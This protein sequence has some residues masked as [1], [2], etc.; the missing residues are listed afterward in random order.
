[1]DNFNFALIVP[2]IIL[3][4]ILVIVALVDLSKREKSKLQGESKLLWVL[5][6]LFIS[7]IGPILYLVIGRKKG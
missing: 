4:L 2:L 5:I 7:T 3:E 6:I 1:M